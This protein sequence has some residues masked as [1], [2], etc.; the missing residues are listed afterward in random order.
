MRKILCSLFLLMS[1]FYGW[2]QIKAELIS[3]SNKQENG[4]TV[5]EMQLSLSN[6]LNTD[7]LI[8]L[9]KIVA[10]SGKQLRADIQGRQ[11][12]LTGGPEFQTGLFYA[13]LFKSLGIESLV[14]L[15]GDTKTERSVESYFNKVKQ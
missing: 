4:K 12:T 14:T 11:L 2:S 1:S 7:G 13:E 15:H 3:Y 5:Y 10:D 8:A 9:D 6:E